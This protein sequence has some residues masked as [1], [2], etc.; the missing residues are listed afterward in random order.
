MLFLIF[1]DLLALC[2][3]EVADVNAYFLV[4]DVFVGVHPFH[5]VHVALSGRMA[6]WLNAQTKE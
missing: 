3:V 1:L 6:R 5:N 2:A 4:G